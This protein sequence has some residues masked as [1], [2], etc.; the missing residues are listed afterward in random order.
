MTAANDNG[1]RN[2]QLFRVVIAGGG[3]AGLEALLALRELAAD[4]LTIT[5]V[6]PVD[7]F[8]YRPL[9]VA[10]P[11]TESRPRGFPLSEIALEQGSAYRR[12]AVVDIDELR[13]RVRLDDG[14]ELDYDALLLAF[15][16]EPAEEVPGALTFA[17]GP[18]SEAFRSLLDETERGLI[19]RVAFAVPDATWWPIAAYELALQ[20]AAYA[21]ARGREGLELVLAT[22]EPRPLEVFGARASSAIVERLESARIELHAGVAP[23]RVEDGQLFLADGTA[24]PCD[25]AVALPAPQVRSIHGLRNQQ[26]RGLIPTDA[27]G[28][29]LG[30]ERIFAAGDATMFPIKQG[31]L[32]AQ[33]ADAA[34]SAIAAL[35]G[36]EVEQRPFRPVLRGALLTGHAPLYLRADPVGGPDSEAA[37]VALWWPPSKIAGRLLAP[38]LASRLGYRD[39]RG[40]SLV[41][42][43]PRAG[44]E[45]ESAGRDHDEVVALALAAADADARWRDYSKAMRWL[46]V[47]EDLDLYLPTEYELKRISWQ[48]LA[49]GEAG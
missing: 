28:A 46:E 35:A 3:V 19:S 18:T 41:D 7:E 22:A 14:S 45:E 6:A 40:R 44:D 48:E 4:R 36:A 15:G 31:G 20:T 34:A 42:L 17:G 49:K 16:A 2:G 47:A 1:A 21:H 32:A 37:R 43:D 9:T 27:L 38:Y 13:R 23:V 10:Q 39:E 8:T 24:I 30:M 5:L 26:P 33:Q 11:F 25:R 29:V 12:G